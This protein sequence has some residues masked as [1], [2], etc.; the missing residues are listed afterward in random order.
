MTSSI[1]PPGPLAY[2]GAVS[3]P[4][5]RHTFNPTT[6]FNQF[7]V[8]TIWVNTA[9]DQAWLLVSVKLGVADW[10]PIGGAAGTLDT[11][12][13]DDHVIVTPTAAN[14]NVFGDGTITKTTGNAATST[15]RV[16]LLKDVTLNYVENVGSASAS[17]G[18]LNVLGTQGVTTTGVTNTVTVVGTPTKA[19]ASSSMSNLGTAS[20][21]SA[22]FSAD[23]NGW[24][25]L[26]G[27]GSAAEEIK[28]DAHTAPGTDPVVPG[29]NGRITI[30]GGQAAAGTIANSIQTNS[31]AANTFTIQV[32]RSSAVAA[33]D[34][35]KNGA[36]HFD[37]ASFGVD[38]NGF[39][40]S[41]TQPSGRILQQVR[42][43]RND[44]EKTNF[45]GSSWTNPAGGSAP[46]ITDGKEFFSVS[47]T[48][49]AASSILCFFV[50]VQAEGG[51]LFGIG[52]FL[53]AGPSSFGAS[54]I[55]QGN[56]TYATNNCF[57]FYTTAG[58]TSTVACSVRIGN[59]EAV[60]KSFYFNGTNF[61][62]GSAMWGGVCQSMLTVTEYSS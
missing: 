37:S 49:K 34:A 17:S 62:G 46:A 50:Q 61:G 45:S 15:V 10:I 6:A 11:L 12:T 27:G 24:V 35:T 41:T 52:A 60:A 25:Q 7:P 48:P 23:A 5:T 47:I 51:E 20:F 54:L 56:S 29:A 22:A 31:L 58:T 42:H 8:P 2:E 40:T 13:T 18:I 36:C 55:T 57:T 30:T 16:E 32:Q 9:T 38:A 59:S 26:K 1:L 33:T 28:V 3:T 39:V 53:G 21:D 43:I 19:V 4:Y 44:Y 14:I